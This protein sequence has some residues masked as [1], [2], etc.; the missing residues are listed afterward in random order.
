MKEENIRLI[1]GLKLKQLRMDQGISQQM[2]S[3]KTGISVSY[4]NE[5]EKGKKYPKPDK[6]AV[7]ADGLGVEYDQLTSL[8]L[9]RNLAPIS[10]LLQSNI[11][12]ELPLDMFNIEANKLLEVLSSDE[13]NKF[14]AFVNTII[15][16][17][18]SYDIKLETFF[19][20]VL[21]SY[22]EMYENYF[23]ELEEAADTFRKEYGLTQDPV[24]RRQILENCLQEQFGYQIEYGGLDAHPDLQDLRSVLIPD[25]KTPRLLLNSSL[26]ERQVIFT[27]G[28]EVGYS[29]LNLTARPYTASW[30]N[31][32]SFEQVLN[33]FKASYFANALLMPEKP[34]I[35]ALK[36]I[37]VEKTFEASQLVELMES[38][39]AT[40]EMFMYRLTNLL[41]KHLGISDLFF[42]RFS[43]DWE[44][45]RIELTK[46]LHLSHHLPHG[47]FLNEHYCRRW[48]SVQALHEAKQLTEAGELTQPI[49]LVQRSFYSENKSEFLIL[50]LARP[51]STVAST[52][53][54]VTI[55]LNL[56][57]TLK[58]KV[59]FWNDPNI[60]TQFV[61][62]TCE[63]CAINDC[64]K[65]VA[66]PVI[67]QE[68]Q[69][70]ETM[71]LVL[72]DLLK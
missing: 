47:T 48:A 19:F 24:A 39:G 2:L 26:T 36:S 35:Q 10:D 62:T 18:R 53:S 1:F 72:Q 11:L 37:F 5:I 60:P 68:E 61:S 14:S 12:S 45:D 69:R 28:R 63:R 17:C 52:L 50:T 13:P 56:N 8:K 7:L 34:F 32:T 23:P 49:C 4:L 71:Q 30:V 44:V 43:S 58:R 57:E 65:R 9:D 67:L 46:E 55:G 54:S 66:R 25:E 6:V 3:R 51:Q 22:Q 59:R 21:R 70:L 15:A 38:S 42:F 31:V 41:P 27:L 20:S 16:V 64:E 33:N 40:P 29:F